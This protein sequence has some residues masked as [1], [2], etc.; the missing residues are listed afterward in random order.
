VEL[1]HPRCAGWMSPKDEVAACVRV[2]DGRGGRA[3]E[4]RTFPT[5]TS[6]LEALVA[7]LAA[8]GVIQAV[9][10]AIGQYWKP[11][12]F[13]LEEL[14]ERRGPSTKTRNTRIVQ[15]PAMRSSACRLGHGAVLGSIAGVGSGSRLSSSEVTGPRKAPRAGAG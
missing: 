3:R 14:G 5:F 7:W 10:E 1:L 9:M 2:P 6:G 12:W 15:R 13:V 11:V 8:K 4:V